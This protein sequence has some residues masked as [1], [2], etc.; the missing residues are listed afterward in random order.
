VSNYVLAIVVQVSLFASAGLVTGWLIRS[1]GLTSLAGGALMGTGAYGFAILTEQ[2]F[3]PFVALSVAGLLGMAAGWALI[4]AR[5]RVIGADFA[6]ASFA[7]QATWYGAAANANGL[8]GGA[9]GI[10]GV[11]P[12][13]LGGAGRIETTLGLAG[14]MLGVV[15]WVQRRASLAMFDVGARVIECST[16]LA[17]SL[18]VP[19][20]SIEA[21]IACGYGLAI[22]LSGSLLAAYLTFVGPATF[23]TDTSI[24]ILALGFFAA[25]TIPRGLLGAVLLIGVPELFRLVGLPPSR[26]A[27][28]RITLAGV[29]TIAAALALGRQRSSRS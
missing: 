4:V 28:L 9:L 27:Y 13:M 19:R 16:E 22:A 18:G 5:W 15:W 23:G 11:P 17:D 29:V 7:L 2:G 20:R 24:S 1:L 26:A 12:L 14:V 3:A 6:L 25:Q 10:S 8:T 21:Q